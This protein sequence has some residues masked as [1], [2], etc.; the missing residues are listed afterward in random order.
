MIE[1]NELLEKTG[2]TIDQLK[3]LRRFRLIPKPI[4]AGTTEQGGSTSYYP[5]ETLD[6]ITYVRAMQAMGTALPKIA[7]Y[8]KETEVIGGTSE[9]DTEAVEVK[10][11]VNPDLDGTAR[12]LWDKVADLLP[13]KKVVGLRV[14]QTIE[15]G[16]PHAYVVGAIVKGEEQP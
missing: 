12:L 14:V 8:L 3:N 13:G 16:Q 5:D 6:R 11:P 2:L 4:R 10:L 9:P 7:E 15:D 1:R